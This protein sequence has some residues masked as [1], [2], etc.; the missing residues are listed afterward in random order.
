MLK[1]KYKA[2]LRGVNSLE[3]VVDE[4]VIW[5]RQR[6]NEAGVNGLVVGVSGGLDSAVVAYLIQKAFP[7]SSLGLVMPLK[8]NES[9]INHADKV[10]KDSRIK[11]LTVDLTDTHTAMFNVIRTEIADE[12]IDENAQLADAN[13]RARLRM[14]TLYTIATNYNYLVVGTD[15]ASEWYTGYFTKYGDGGVDI[16]PI[17]DFTKDEVMDIALYLGVPDEIVNK[18]PSADLW[19]GQTDEN[20]MGTTYKAIDAFIKG[21]DVSEKDR[22]TIEAMHRKT[23]HKRSPLPKYRREN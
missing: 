22:E 11:G 4:I 20:E 5:L 2:F 12:F 17:I 8:T 21:Q 13:L 15:N 1:F 16:Q 14:S 7:E 9:D 6:V 23:I 18:N 19:E 3:R 10:I